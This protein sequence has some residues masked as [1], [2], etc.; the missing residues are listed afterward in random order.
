[1]Q[2]I[3]VSIIGT[4][5]WAD[6]I[7][8][9][10]LQAHPAAELAAIWGRNRERA[11][12]LAASYNIAGIFGDYRRM[13]DEANLDAIIVATPDDVHFPMTMAALGAGLHVL[14]EK[15]L[16]LNAAQAREMYE[17]AEA[18]GVRHMFLFT[19]RWLPPDST[20]GP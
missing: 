17:K 9:P 1:M 19:W 3:R 20:R 16:A 15:P 12:A 5:W 7:Y 6:M 14:C 4:S 8:L 13:I 11:E 10:S 18:A 2:Q